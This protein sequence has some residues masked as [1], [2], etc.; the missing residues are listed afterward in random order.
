M[1]IWMQ[2]GVLGVVFLSVIRTFLWLV[3]RREVHHDHELEAANARLEAALARSSDARSDGLRQPSAGS[4]RELIEARDGDA[5]RRAEQ[6]RCL[7]G[8]IKSSKHVLK[9]MA[10]DGCRNRPRRQRRT[11]R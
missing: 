11:M 7:I 5:D 10:E 1:D 8:E 2:L 6:M 4:I 9:T 3:N